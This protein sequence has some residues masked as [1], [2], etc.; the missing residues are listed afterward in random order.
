MDDRVL[1]AVF[2]GPMVIP[3]KNLQNSTMWQILLSHGF[4]TF[5][6]DAMLPA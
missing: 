1:G 3:F 6:G 2:G 5:G 4:A